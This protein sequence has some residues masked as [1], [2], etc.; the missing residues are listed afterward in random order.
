MLALLLLLQVIPED[1][2]ADWKSAGVPGG[3]PKRTRV[4]EVKGELQA[5]I[6]AA[7]PEDVV[8]LPA[9][10]Y[11]GARLKSR[12]TLRGAG[13]G[14]TILKGPIS[15]GQGGADWWY[16]NRHRVDVLGKRGVDVL[17]CDAS[18]LGV[19]DVVQLSR[20]NNLDLPVITP[21]GF[22][23]LQRQVTRIVAKT[24]TSVTV[25]PAPLFDLPEGSRLAA[26]GR[27]AEFVGIEDLGVEG[28]GQVGINISGAYGCW[29]KNVAVK[30]ISNYHV[31]ISDALHCEIRHSTIATRQGAGSNGAGILMGTSSFC[32]V[33]D[34][35]LLE[36]F[37]HLEINASCGNVFAYNYCRDS[38]IQGV[39]GCSINS[40]HGPH[41]CFNLYE[42]NVSPKFQ[43]DGYHGSS[44]HDTVFRN[45]L[46][47]TSEK[48]KLFWICV[49]LNRFTRNYSIVGNV[50][51]AP[52][53]PWLYDNAEKGYGY[54]QHLIYSW[55][56]PNMGN[57][58]FRGTSSRHSWK[59]W[60]TSPGPGGFQEL[61]L[62]VRRTTIVKGNF[63]WKDAG[64]P[65]AEA[66]ENLPKS[67]YLKAK[68]SWWG[69]LAWPPF[70]PDV[71][72]EKNKIPAE[73]R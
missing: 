4:V 61:D 59:D 38:D 11:G 60:G 56:M 57:G 30:N 34:N 69:D 68:P 63:N 14:K 25:A 35:I 28:A 37:P 71:A 21:G 42:G 24:P 55:G 41:S 66:V 23:F 43:A 65:A 16:P 36:Q 20:K 44:S 22:D 67:C 8:Y 5:A 33:E 40:N 26:G 1:R 10:T 31:S 52:G 39:V 6:D 17:R 50:L 47:G 18:K 48:T 53:H 19:G 2:L 58:G 12:I 7:Q 13:P 32:K 64:V 3:I 15:V 46:H 62:D 72:F 45:R 51:G 54:D 29:V 49:N 73:T 9:G 70:G 27:M